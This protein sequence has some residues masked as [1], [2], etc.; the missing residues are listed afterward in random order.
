MPS[1]LEMARRSISALRSAGLDGDDLVRS[2]QAIESYVMGSTLFDLIGAPDNM[3]IRAARYRALA[4]P[5]FAARGRSASKV[6]AVTEEAFVA[7]LRA[8]LDEAFGPR[9]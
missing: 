2:Y 5:A 3:E 7:G 1:A 4:D 8:V 6:D 9:A